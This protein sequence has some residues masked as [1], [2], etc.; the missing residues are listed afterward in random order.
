MNDFLKSKVIRNDMDE[1]FN[2]GEYCFLRNKTV[3][4]TGAYGMLASYMVYYLIYLN[5]EH[6]Y[7]IK[8]ITVSRNKEKLDCLLGPHIHEVINI[9]KSIND[10]IEIECDYIV[11]AASLASPQHYTIR[12]IDVILPNV[13]G[14]YNMLELAYKNNAKL[15]FFSSC[16]VYGNFS[17][18]KTIIT[19]EDFGIIN[20]LDL[21]S[22]YDESKRAGETLCVAYYRQ[23]KVPIII[24]RIAHTYGPTMDI[25]NDPRVFS[26][27]IKNAVNKENIEIKSDGSAKR[28]FCYISD[29][30]TAYFK[31]L[32]DGTNGEAYNVCNTEQTVSIKVL[33]DVISRLAG[34]S[35]KYIKR[36]DDDS[37]LEDTNTNTLLYTSD[38]LIKLGFSFNVNLEDGF[39]RVLSYFEETRI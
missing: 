38:K 1:I 39:K 25:N 18:D 6:N 27:F 14:T 2:D 4:V 21:H 20:P 24:A 15:L 8:I 22:C 33:G 11:H 3:L 31:L 32:K 12:P 5:I 28:S 30:V 13:I 17:D 35:F 7:N 9:N 10:F 26:S 36:S 19:E 16:C 23:K 37:Y 29:A 34:V